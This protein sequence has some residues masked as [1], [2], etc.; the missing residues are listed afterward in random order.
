MTGRIG[1]AM[2]RPGSSMANR[3]VPGTASRLEKKKF[4]EGE[5]N[6]GLLETFSRYG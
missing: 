4:G 6:E 5:E 1:S 3:G 2:G